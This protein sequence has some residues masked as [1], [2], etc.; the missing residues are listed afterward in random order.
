MDM[1]VTI[2]RMSFFMG[3]PIFL[4]TGDYASLV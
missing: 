1:R 2:G 4:I 3:F